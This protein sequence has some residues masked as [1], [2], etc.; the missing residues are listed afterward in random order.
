MKFFKKNKK[1]IYTLIPVL[2]L[3]I[4]ILFPD[5]VSASVGT[6]VAT[7]L[8]W[9]LYPIIWLMGKL[10]ILLIGILIGI[11][12]YNEFINSNAVSFGWALVR[13]LCNMFF[14]LILLVIAF[15][16]ILRIESYN[17][18]TWLPKLL[19]MAVLINFSKL[20]CGVFIDFTQVIMLTF[21]NAFKDLAGA[22]LTEM[23]GISKILSFESSGTDDVTGWS[24]LGSVILALIFS[25]ISVVVILSMLVMLAMRIIMIWIYVV[26]SPLAYLLASFPQGATY[27]QRWWSEFSKNL[28]IGP[29]LAFFIWLS[30]AS[31]GGVEGSNDIQKMKNTTYD[32]QG[33]EL[34][35]M[36]GSAG[37]TEAGSYDHMLKFII[38]IGMLLGGMMIAQEMGGV[39]GKALGKVSGKLNAAVTKGAKRVTG[40]ERAE[41]AIKSYRSQK[42]S[43][44]QDLAQRDAG[45]LMKGEAKIK[46]AVAK[47][48]QAVAGG[49]GDLA[50]KVF[51]VSNS[52][53]KRQEDAIAKKQETKKSLQEQTSTLN[54]EAEK[55]SDNKE[56]LLNVQGEVKMM[57]GKV[58]DL[59]NERSL[60]LGDIDKQIEEER[61]NPVNGVVNFNKINDLK[62]EKDKVNQD[63]DKKVQDVES[64]V[65]SNYNR[66]TGKNVS[67]VNVVKAEIDKD[68]DSAEKMIIAKNQDIDKNKDKEDDISDEIKEDEEDL[69][70]KRKRAENVGRLAPMVLGIAAGT[71]FGGVGG[72]LLGGT[73]AGS[74][75]GGL[76]MMGRKKLK[77]AGKDALD[78]S[79]NFNSSQINKHKEALKEEKSDVLK[80]KMNDYGIS[81]HERSAA[82]MLLMEKGKLSQEDAEVKRDEIKK[83]FGG[84]NR[85]MNQLDSSLNN[86]YQ[87][88]TRDF[89]DLNDGKKDNESDKAYQDRVD[90]AKTKIVKGVVSGTIK[91]ENIDKG[92][93]DLIMPELVKT[94]SN[95]SFKNKYDDMTK[96]KQRD[97]RESLKSSG[98]YDSLRKLATI[99]DSDLNSF[100]DEEQK[101]KFLG[102]IEIDE[103]KKMTSKGS[104]FAAARKFISTTSNPEVQ[105]LR[106]DSKTEREF[107][108]N[109]NS[110]LKNSK[111]SLDVPAERAI[112]RAFQEMSG[113]SFNNQNNQQGASPTI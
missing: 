35:G 113:V 33:N 69:T 81:S 56:I 66:A 63:Y 6:V 7:V 82:A 43:K 8:G 58:N 26:L 55:L 107:V 72:S 104:S 30:F 77:N 97:M 19:I 61:N 29:V 51:G 73:L 14:I 22:N 53:L 13:D 92:S 52:Q 88:L 100:E 23:L 90:G 46:R 42:E 45:M 62:A 93:M 64:S 103:V 25:V 91:I 102:E 78:L 50:K 28:I 95:K 49:A 54:K 112:I 37:L 18:K 48:V 110:I 17:L 109:L 96:D 83:S 94:M 47:P 2:L 32:D 1:I 75:A 111:L 65:I 57:D 68:I 10:V 11:A 15:A 16:T 67:D 80:Q 79:S 9:I 31:L 38:S 34:V 44:R 105:K 89:S 20:I 39:A 3:G 12:Q 99:Q 70:R 106:I 84:D 101:V 40:V 74:A 86:D 36:E 87:K 41:N 27:S 98:E 5:V 21:V 76:G 24:I 59:N 60:A 71:V 108:N 4:F 85:V